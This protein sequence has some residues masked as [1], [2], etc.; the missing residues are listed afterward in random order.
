MQKNYV[1]YH[2]SCF[3]GSGA[4]YAAWSKLGDK[5]TTYIP[6]QYQQPPPE[7][8]SGSNVYILDFSYPKDVLTGLLDASNSLV[9]LD[10]HKTAKEALEGFPGAVFDMD[11][12]GAILAWEYFHPSERPPALLEHIQDRDLWKWNLVGTKEVTAGLQLIKDFRE[13]ST[14]TT[15]E[16]LFE[17]FRRGVVKTGFDN[18]EIEASLKKATIT[19]YPGPPGETFLCAF[20]NANNLISEIGNYLCQELSVDFSLS[21]F[22]DKSGDVTFSFRSIGD[23]DVSKLAKEL[24]GGGHRNASGAKVKGDIGMKFISQLY[25]GRTG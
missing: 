1:L 7:M 23:F 6:V 10:H 25:S 18:M 3:D 4:A 20:L 15:K 24:G 16:G 17:L 21:Y 12:S 9:V 13:F 19:R 2:A 22:I 8:E 14:A 11:K 5:D